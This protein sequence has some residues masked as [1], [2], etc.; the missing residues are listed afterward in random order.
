[1]LA[2]AEMLR[3]EFGIGIDAHSGGVGA[4]AGAVNRA[5][6]TVAAVVLGDAWLASVVLAPETVL[7][8]LIRGEADG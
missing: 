1:M 8:E 7:E 2:L 6:R 5:F 3:A 4:E